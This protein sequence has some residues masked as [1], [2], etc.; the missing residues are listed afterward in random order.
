MAQP[1]LDLLPILRHCEKDGGNYI[2]SGVMITR[3]PVWGRIWIF[4][5]ACK[6]T[7]LH[8]CACGEGQAF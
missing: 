5:A 2:S 8:G 1:D 7:P 3:H 4:T 6:L